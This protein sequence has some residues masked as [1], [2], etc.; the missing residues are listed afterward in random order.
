MCH[1]ILTILSLTATTPALGNYAGRVDTVGGT[2]YDWQLSGPVKRTLVS[3]PPYGLH[4]L[5]LYS[6]LPD[7]FTDRNMR[8]NFYDFTTRSWHFLATEFIGSGCNVYSQRSGFGNLQADP[9][10]GVAWI[11]A[12][13]ATSTGTNPVLAR[14][15]QPGAGIF[16]FSWG[17]DSLLWPVLALDPDR[18]AHVAV[19]DDGQ[20]EQVIYT[21]CPDWQ[22][23]TTPRTLGEPGY[24]SFNIATAPDN[25]RKIAVTWV[26]WETQ[27]SIYLALSRD[28]GATWETERLAPPRAYLGDTLTCISLFGPFP[29]FDHQ[30]W[31]HI[32]TD[33]YPVINDT[34]YIVPAGIWHWCEVNE[35]QWSQVR[36]A[37]CRL[38]VI[39][40]PIGYNVNYCCHPSIGTDAAGNLYVAWEEFDSLN[41]EPQTN[42][43]RA[44][45]LLAVST[46]NGES[47]SPA[48]QI[49][50]SNEISHRFPCIVDRLLAGP[51]DTIAV[52]YMMDSTAGFYVQNQ[53]PMSTNPVVCQFVPVSLLG[54][55]EADRNPTPPAEPATTI[56]RGPLKLSPG[57]FSSSSLLLIDACGRRVLALQPGINSLSHL[58]PGIYF[59]T[60]PEGARATRK[61]VLTK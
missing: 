52:V 16:E 51:P 47:W 22:N 11:V 4:C 12:H 13:I 43:L 60:E 39:R 33:V 31:L 19:M 36:R 57:I 41:V 7:P 24:P 25:S 29:W 34:D 35:P 54:I 44:N 9:V 46:D 30:G 15:L 49:T 48:L 17:P 21:S 56:T 23:W 5:W 27:D 61:L 58:A 28:G 14:D 20:R 53:G 40:A 38:E 59:I 32:V 42:L 3:A 2:T 18:C 6:A 55:S 8:Y 45:I 26:N 10:T 37:G 1:V 50:P